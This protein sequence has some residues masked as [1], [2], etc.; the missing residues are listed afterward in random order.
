MRMFPFYCLTSWHHFL[1][2]KL[3]LMLQLMVPIYIFDICQALLCE[4]LLC[5][6]QYQSQ[7]YQYKSLKY[8]YQRCHRRFCTFLC[9]ISTNI[10][11]PTRPYLVPIKQRFHRTRG[12]KEQPIQAKTQSC[13]ND[14]SF[15]FL[16]LLA[17]PI[18]V[19]LINKKKGL[20]TKR[21]D[22]CVLKFK[23]KF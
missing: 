21:C 2:V 3:N 8:L 9:K 10:P 22:A 12:M 1:F 14:S 17:C 23:I 20:I 7:C 18:L 11:K 16:L 4:A 6:G 5:E 19:P 13:K 15:L